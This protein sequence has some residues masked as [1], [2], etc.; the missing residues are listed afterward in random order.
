ME[1]WIGIALWLIIGAG[2]G[3]VVKS[4]RREPREQPGHAA[5]IAVLGAFGAL[6]G[7]MLGVGT[8]HLDEPLSLSIGGMAGA[9]LLATVSAVLYRWGVRGMT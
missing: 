9:V 6:I 7:G 3:L 5:V 1:N 2:I 8:F 4:L